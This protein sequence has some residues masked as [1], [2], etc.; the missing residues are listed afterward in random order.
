MMASISEVRASPTDS[1][2]ARSSPLAMLAVRIA[3]APIPTH[4]MEHI[5]EKKLHFPAMFF[6]TKNFLSIVSL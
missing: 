1:S 2:E 3:P 5:F 4:F 6:D